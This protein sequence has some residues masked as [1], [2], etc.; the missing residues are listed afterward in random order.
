MVG[1]V[2]REGDDFSDRSV[3]L[4]RKTAG[5]NKVGG[6]GVVTGEDTRKQT[7]QIQ[8]AKIEGEDDTLLHG[9]KSEE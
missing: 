1:L 2:R 4:R 7:I 3:R 6:T 5:Y 9:E 8:F